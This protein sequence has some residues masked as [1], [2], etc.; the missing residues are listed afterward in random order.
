LEEGGKMKYLIAIM[1]CL[2]LAGA[3]E[4]VFD[5][6]DLGGYY[7]EYIDEFKIPMNYTS[8]TVS[9]DKIKDMVFEN[10]NLVINFKAD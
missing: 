2:Y 10:G 7:T 6:N 5:S 9:I 4:L 1:L 3:Q 8:I